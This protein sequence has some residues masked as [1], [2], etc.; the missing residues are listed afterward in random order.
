MAYLLFAAH[1]LEDSCTYLFS[2]SLFRHTQHPK[3]EAC[4]R[5]AIFGEGSRIIGNAIFHVKGD[6][7]RP[8]QAEIIENQTLNELIGWPRYLHDAND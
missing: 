8:E 4:P 2:L 7:L 1:F 3:L 6:L 5:R